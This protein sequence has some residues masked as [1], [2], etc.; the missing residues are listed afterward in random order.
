MESM[1]NAYATNMSQIEEC[2]TKLSYN[3][4]L[5]E[6]NNDTCNKLSRIVNRTSC[7]I[8]IDLCKK[9]TKSI[10]NINEM[11]LSDEVSNTD[12]YKL[13]LNYA[14]KFEIL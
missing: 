2:V 10:R 9:L 11:D 12:K 3:Y 7:L 14:Y 8:S 6:Q 1:N 4:D 5:Y 13:L